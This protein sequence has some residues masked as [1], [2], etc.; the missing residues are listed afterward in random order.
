MEYFKVIKVLDWN[1]ISESSD[2]TK[3]GHQIGQAEILFAQIEDAEIQKQLDKLE[4]T[5]T[6]NKVLK[7]QK[8]NRKKTSL[9]SKISLK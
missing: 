6:A 1:V 2:L 4:A 5:K 7:T 9:L 8:L 3:A